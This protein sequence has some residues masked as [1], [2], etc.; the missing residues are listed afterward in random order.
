MKYSDWGTRK[1]Y[2]E[3]CEHVEIMMEGWWRAWQHN[4]ASS[5][6]R[7]EDGESLLELIYGHVQGFR[8]M[9]SYLEDD[10]ATGRGLYFPILCKEQQLLINITLPSTNIININNK[11]WDLTTRKVLA[12]SYFK[13]YSFFLLSLLLSRSDIAASG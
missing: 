2:G 11:D 8:S 1:S 12:S 7:R 4:I 10:S 9:Q 13:V 6:D 3:Y 5:E